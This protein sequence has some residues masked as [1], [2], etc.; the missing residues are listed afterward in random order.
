MYATIAHM[1][2]VHYLNGLILVLGSK[3]FE[4]RYSESIVADTQH[5]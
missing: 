4:E 5:I 3:M 1:K 2:V